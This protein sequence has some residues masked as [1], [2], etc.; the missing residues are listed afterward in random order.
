[1]VNHIVERFLNYPDALV[2][3]WPPAFET[4]AL[5]RRFSDGTRAADP[6]SRRVSAVRNQSD[7]NPFRVVF[8]FKL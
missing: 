5:R 6:G 4:G 1:M 3:E 2:L 8:E 7:H